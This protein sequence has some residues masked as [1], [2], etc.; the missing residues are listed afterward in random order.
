MYNM[1]RGGFIMRILD[2]IFPKR[3]VGCGKIGKYF[4][5]SCRAT[6]RI[7]KSNE[8]ICPMCE[9]PA[10]EGFTHPR[11]QTRYSLD[12]LTSFFH[13]NG[14]VR[15]AVKA[16]KY[17]MVSDLANEFMHLVPANSL[18]SMI[19]DPRSILVPVPLHPKRLRDR[20]FNQAELLGK[21][22]AAHLRVPMRTDIL[23]RVKETVPQVEMKKRDARLKNMEGVF[24]LNIDALTHRR[25]DTVLL[26]DDVFT[27]GATMR[28]AVNVLKRA[29]VKR[30]WA[31]TMVR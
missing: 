13:Y 10:I 20:G 3:C 4:C 14:P 23:R 8:P 9:K 28:S 18:Q 6:I 24:E 16:I 5:D 29:G 12:G 15:K 1:Y 17:R 2:I 27:T 31:V 25:I 26:F 7:I 30:V 19:Y 21:L 11:C 22:L